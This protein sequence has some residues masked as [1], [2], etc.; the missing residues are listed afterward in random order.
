MEQVDLDPVSG[1]FDPCLCNDHLTLFSCEFNP[2]L[3]HLFWLSAWN[4]MQRCTSGWQNMPES[5]VFNNFHF[6][7]WHG[8]KSDR[9]MEEEE[10]RG[11]KNKLPSICRQKVNYPL[12][13]IFV[14]TTSDLYQIYRRPFFRRSG[15]LALD[16]TKKMQ[17]SLSRCKKVDVNLLV[18]ADLGNCCLGHSI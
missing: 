10:R 12:F 4:L 2:F 17:A 16:R 13:K 3:Q 11:G 18:L 5:L 9:H 14:V 6:I 1:T 7:P 15:N 8:K